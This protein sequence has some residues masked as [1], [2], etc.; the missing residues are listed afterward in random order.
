[1]ITQPS[2]TDNL[3][4]EILNDSQQL[5]FLSEFLSGETYEV[6][7]KSLGMFLRF[8]PKDFTRALWSASRCRCR[9]YRKF[10]KGAKAAE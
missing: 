6:V 5:E 10:V 8:S 4:D 9:V 1:M 7:E 3:E 2:E